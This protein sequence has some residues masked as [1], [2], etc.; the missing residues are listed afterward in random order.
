MRRSGNLCLSRRNSRSF[1]L[2]D[3]NSNEHFFPQPIFAAGLTHSRKRNSRR[4]FLFRKGRRQPG[5]SPMDTEEAS[6]WSCNA[7][8]E[9]DE[10][11]RSAFQRNWIASVFILFLIQSKINSL[12]KIRVREMA[13]ES[14]QEQ[15]Q[16]RS[17]PIAMAIANNRGSN[18]TSIFQNDRPSQCLPPSF[19]PCRTIGR[20]IWALVKKA[21]GRTAP[22]RRWHR[23]HG[24]GC[25]LR[26]QS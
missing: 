14:G 6:T 23:P 19:R 3:D 7:H 15:K 13:K 22:L 12:T 5:C 18:F 9:S 21:L 1:F 2:F 8:D 24:P 10:G 20:S 11:A 4:V 17:T 25:R 16:L 26:A